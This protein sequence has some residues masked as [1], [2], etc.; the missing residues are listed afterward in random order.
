LPAIHAI[1]ACAVCNHGTNKDVSIIFPSLFCAI[2]L[3]AR[4]ARAGA[5]VKALYP[6][7]YPSF[8]QRNAQQSTRKPDFLQK[9]EQKVIA[10]CAFSN[11]EEAIFHS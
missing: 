3:R 4:L 8:T 1:A 2:S 10:A 7:P 11:S 5:A 6:Q 9:A